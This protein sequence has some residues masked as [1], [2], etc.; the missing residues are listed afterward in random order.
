[1][2]QFFVKPYEV[3]ILRKYVCI[4]K[5]TCRSKGP[6]VYKNGSKQVFSH[7]SAVKIVTKQSALLIVWGCALQGRAAEL[8]RLQIALLTACPKLCHSAVGGTDMPIPYQKIFCHMVLNC[9]FN[10]L[11]FVIM[12]HEKV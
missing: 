8:P 10:F 1:M 9:G 3:R 11:G 2:G 7:L 6:V 4:S 5:N 12:R